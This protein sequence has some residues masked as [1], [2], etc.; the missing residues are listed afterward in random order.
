MQTSATGTQTVAYRA[1]LGKWLTKQRQSKKGNGP[2]LSQEREFQLQ[3]L[4]DQGKLLWDASAMKVR[5]P[6]EAP[7]PLQY[8]ALLEYGHQHGHC[9]VPH[10]ARFDCDVPDGTGSVVHYS[11][12]LGR[13]LS[14]Q[15][16]VFK[17]EKS[18]LK[19]PSPERRALLQSL[20]DQGL[21]F[22]D[23]SCRRGS[24][25]KCRKSTDLSWPRN[26]AALLQYAAEHGHCNVP[27]D[28]VYE[29]EIPGADGSAEQVSCKLGNWLHDQR[30]SHRGTGHSA[31]LTPEREAL[32]QALVDE[33]KLNCDSCC[34]LLKVCN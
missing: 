18:V 7:W 29:C 22:W 8:A 10:N 21:L 19:R 2:K 16:Q 11:G 33:G 23:A 34:K 12:D 6:K 24:N 4:V 5:P 32:L 15:R 27:H 25:G 3:Q 13:W 1:N 26:Y 28:A 14:I 17:G 9:N 31:K 30:Q 20:V